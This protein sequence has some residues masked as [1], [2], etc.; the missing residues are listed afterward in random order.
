[1]LSDFDDFDNDMYI[2]EE[3]Y[4]FPTIK[5]NELLENHINLMKNFADFKIESIKEIKLPSKV[6]KNNILDNRHI[7]IFSNE[8]HVMSNE[9]SH[10]E[11]S[12]FSLSHYL[13]SYINKTLTVKEVR[14]VIPILT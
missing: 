5:K 9:K 12:K 10:P 1:M 3:N 2:D 13:Y 14:Q 7:S 4:N 8:Y 11:K 6:D